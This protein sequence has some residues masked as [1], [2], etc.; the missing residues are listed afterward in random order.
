MFKRYI[1]W[2]NR[3]SSPM[4]EE[5]WVQSQ[6]EL[7]QRLKKSHLMPPCLTQHYKVWIKGKW[8]NPGKGVAPFP[9]P[10]C[11]SYGKGSLQ[12]ALNDN[13]PTYFV[14]DDGTLHF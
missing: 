3:Y 1:H 9:T 4:I 11:S 13:R 14:K 5:T 2:H 7:Y 10:R 8:S 6:V 12:V